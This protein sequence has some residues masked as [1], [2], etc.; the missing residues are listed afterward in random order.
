MF[1]IFFMI[2]LG[3]INLWGGWSIIGGIVMNLGIWSYEGVV[4]VY[5]VFFGLC[6]LVVIW[7]WVY[8]DL[9][10]FCDECIGKFFLDLLKIF[11]IYLFF[12]GV[13]CFGFGVFYV[14]GLYGFGIWVFDFYGL[15]GKV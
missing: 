10:I 3:I 15:M 12:L 6:F 11:G 1:V 8:W 14:I 5:I 7:Y 13:V 4:G 2:C 9:E